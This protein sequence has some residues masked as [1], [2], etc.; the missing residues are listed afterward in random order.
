M[1]KATSQSAHSYLVS[2]L[3]CFDH[4]TI[5]EHTTHRRLPSVISDGKWQIV[6]LSG[7]LTEDWISQLSR[8]DFHICRRFLVSLIDEN[9]SICIVLF[10]NRYAF[11][12]NKSKNSFFYYLIV[13]HI[14]AEK[15]ICISV[16]STKS[17]FSLYSWI[18]QR[19][20]MIGL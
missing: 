8:V 6:S 11:S 7:F 15:L 10:S 18:M 9:Q 19:D 17:L 20:F 3:C 12:M 16:L 2:D 4:L 5:A 1:H 14:D 13:F